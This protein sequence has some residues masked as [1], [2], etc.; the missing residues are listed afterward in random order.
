MGKKPLIIL[1][2]MPALQPLSLRLSRTVAP[3]GHSALRSASVVTLEGEV[4]S[5][6]ANR[7]GQLGLGD[8]D[9]REQAEACQA[10]L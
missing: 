10:A 8:T 5:W 6:G 3:S 4:F 2:N 9:R 1:R 7:S